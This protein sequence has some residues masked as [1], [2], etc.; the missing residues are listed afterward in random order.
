MTKSKSKSKRNFFVYTIACGEA[1]KEEYQR[2]KSVVFITST[3]ADE[4]S[5]RLIKRK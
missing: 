5:V 2:K 3:R 1:F 4:R